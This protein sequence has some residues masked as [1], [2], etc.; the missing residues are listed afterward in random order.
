MFDRFSERCRLAFTAAR[1][2]AARLRHDRIGCGHLLLG[3]LDVGSGVAASA[4]RHL[5]ADVQQ[6]RHDVERAMPRGHTHGASAAAMPF[7]AD[8]HAALQAACRHA[9]ARGHAYLGTEH[10]LFGVVAEA[11]GAIAEVLRRHRV[12]RDETAAAA[13]ELRVDLDRS[14]DGA[15]PRRVGPSPLERYGIDLTARDAGGP[16]RAISSRFPELERIEAILAGAA[17]RAAAIIAPSGAGKTS[18]LAAL[19]RDFATGRAP[20]RLVAARLVA[21]EPLEFLRGTRKRR[22]SEERIDALIDA[23]RARDVVL[24]FDDAEWLGGDGDSPAIARLADAISRDAIACVFAA[25]TLSPG[26][27]AT[28]R[29]FTLEPPDSVRALAMASDLRPSLETRHGIEIDDAATRLAVQLAMGAGDAARVV[30]RAL[31]LLDATCARIATEAETPP[32]GI[33]R[34]ERDLE[35]HEHERALAFRREDFS[36]AARFF[37]EQRVIRDRL[38]EERERWTFE[39]R[40]RIRLVDGDAVARTFAREGGAAALRVAPPRSAGPSR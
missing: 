8:G 28:T 13:A 4:L 14:G 22:D 33:V 1:D 6:L 20:Q 21:I 15:A 19:A 23:A 29:I 7:D 38:D 25:T 34:L 37:E 31:R 39:L 24:A 27:A 9:V 5:G 40:S 32:L 35:R 30:G 3:L 10:L 16:P 2:H 17:P 11:R 12:T 18:L 36:A 26:L